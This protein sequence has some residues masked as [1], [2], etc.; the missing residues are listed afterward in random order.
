MTA[1]RIPRATP[2]TPAASAPAAQDA[3]GTK[4]GLLR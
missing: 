1:T 2:A 4:E 3:P